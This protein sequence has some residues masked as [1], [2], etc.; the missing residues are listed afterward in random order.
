M[1]VFFLLILQRMIATPFW[2]KVDADAVGNGLIIDLFL[3]RT[4]EGQTWWEDEE[5]KIEN[6]VQ[7]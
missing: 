6:V 7:H 2:L 5:M 4:D 3:H 1:N